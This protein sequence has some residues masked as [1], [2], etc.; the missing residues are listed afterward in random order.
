[1]VSRLALVRKSSLAETFRLDYYGRSYYTP[2]LILILLAIVLG[3]AAYESG[4]L[5]G[6]FIGLSGLIPGINK[7]L[8][9]FIIYLA[10]FILLYSGK[11][12]V[13]EIVMM[14]LVGIMGLVFI[15]TLFFVEIDFQKMISGLNP[16]IPE[17][18]WL[19]VLGLVGT[20]VV[21]YNIFLHSSTL[22]KKWTSVKSLKE[23]RFDT[24]FSIL[25]GGIITI[26]ILIT[27]AT[28][29][30]PS[31]QSISGLNEL[32]MQ[33]EPS[34]GQ[35]STILIS[36]GILSAGITS[37]ITAPLAAGLVVAEFFPNAKDKY[38]LNRVTWISI[39]TIGVLIASFEIRPILLIQ[40]A[41]F[42]NGLLLPVIVILLLVMINSRKMEMYANSWKQN[43]LGLM[44][45]TTVLILGAK[46]IIASLNLL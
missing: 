8:G 14:V 42:A 6:A 35:F 34:L 32:A 11:L 4:N 44:V 1:M 43:V 2:L 9:L 46:G 12:K 33:L 29:L 45:L 15:V 27:A 7:E 16:T 38:Q 30:N 24:V 36:I 17:G 39:L 22:G 26:A 13:L 20:T 18:S 37:T 40:L 28:T 19:L 31:N 23:V 10:A 3:N 25:I 5:A 41:Q 21:P